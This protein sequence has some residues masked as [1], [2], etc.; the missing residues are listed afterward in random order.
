MKS[1]EVEEMCLEV[2][3]YRCSQPCVLKVTVGVEGYSIHPRHSTLFFKCIDDVGKVV[4][5]VQLARPHEGVSFVSFLMAEKKEYSM[6]TVLP[7]YH[8]IAGSFAPSLEMCVCTGRRG[9]GILK[10]HKACCSDACL[11][12]TQVIRP[13]AHR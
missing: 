3:E 2:F 13:P 1:F 12:R 7:N 10:I 11:D 4:D 9:G 6:K 5:D 8:S